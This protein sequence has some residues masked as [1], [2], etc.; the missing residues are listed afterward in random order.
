MTKAWETTTHALN[1]WI[2]KVLVDK[3]KV[4]AYSKVTKQK[5]GLDV[6]YTADSNG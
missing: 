3:V 4:R 6:I 1:G 2:D 5:F